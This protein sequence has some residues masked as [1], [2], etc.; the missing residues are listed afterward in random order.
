MIQSH[1]LCQLSY[2]AIVQRK[3]KIR[4]PAHLVQPAALPLRAVFKQRP[5]APP[6]S[7]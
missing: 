1:A 4:R 2:R 7:A 5:E 6:C 3:A